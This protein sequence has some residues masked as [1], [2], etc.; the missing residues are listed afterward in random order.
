M[1]YLI[2][3][4]PTSRIYIGYT[5]DFPRRL[6]QHNGEIVGGAKRTRKG[7]PWDPVCVIEGFHDNSSALRFEYRLHHPGRRCPKSQTPLEFNLNNM[8]TLIERGDGPALEWPKL[9]I[10][11]FGT[12]FWIRH[13]KVVNRYLP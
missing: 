3:S 10:H 1:C 12:R 4:R 8:V 11:W 2:K 5:V 6:R 7:R 9:Y 13:P